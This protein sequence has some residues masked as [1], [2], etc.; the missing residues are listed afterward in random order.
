M[1]TIDFAEILLNKII[2]KYREVGEVD[3]EIILN[4]EGL[5]RMGVSKSQHIMWIDRASEG[6]L[7]GVPF[8]CEPEMYQMYA[9]KILRRKSNENL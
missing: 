8:R 3:I 4:Y 7:F 9:I 1:E 5:M 2:E 6:T